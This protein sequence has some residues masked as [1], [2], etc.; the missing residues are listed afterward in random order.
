LTDNQLP[1]LFPAAFF[2]FAMIVCIIRAHRE[3]NKTFYLGAGV[4]F[5]VLLGVISVSFQQAFLF[6]FF[7]FSAAALAIVGMPKI[8]KLVEQK[9]AKNLRE[10]DISAPLKAKDLFT[11]TCLLKTAYKYGV[12]KALFLFCLLMTIAIVGGLLIVG[13]WLGM[14]VDFIV[15]YMFSFTIP[16]IAIY[17]RTMSKALKSIKKR[18]DDESSVIGDG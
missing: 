7:A 1:L 5:L 17:Y 18:S 9:T 12:R 14:S 6:F 13:P 2:G 3:K 11:Q 4:A 16:T 8:N 15:P 10:V